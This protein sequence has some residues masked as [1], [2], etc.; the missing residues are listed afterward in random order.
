MKLSNSGYAILASA[1]VSAATL[2]M[3][4]P[5]QRFAVAADNWTPAPTAAPQFHILGRVALQANEDNT[6]GYV[7][8]SSGTYILSLTLHHPH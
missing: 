5:T 8:G 2:H 7:S 1:L 6:C 3:P 4:E